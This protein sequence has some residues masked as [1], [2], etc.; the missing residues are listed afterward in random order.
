MSALR[1]VIADDE[2]LARSLLRSMLVDHGDVE[3]VAEAGDGRSAVRAIT[4]HR[5]DLVFLDVQMPEL[6]GF[7]VV[8][9]LGVDRMPPVIFVT[10]YDQ[11]AIRAF[12]IHA[13]DY[14][15]K[16]FDAERVDRALR[17]AQSRLSEPGLADLGL[18]LAELLKGARE[19]GKKFPERL[20]IKREGRVRFVD[21]DEIDWIEADGKT[22]RVHAGKEVHVLRDTMTSLEARLD[23]KRFTRLHRS[24][25]VNMG[26]IREVQ[27][28][29]QGD[30]VVILSDGTRLTTGRVYRDNVRKLIEQ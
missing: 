15:L 24:T 16:P 25:I 5:P 21:M 10:A 3:V 26:R 20:P 1:A 28:W 29:F 11:Y 19:P 27:P 13:L 23:P 6:D 4:E 30:F 12:D 2:P 17:R 7:G 8:E 18:R 14:L 22:L 9:T